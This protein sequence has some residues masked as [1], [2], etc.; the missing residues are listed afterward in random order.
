[1]NLYK[2]MSKEELDLGYDCTKTV[3]D[4]PSVYESCKERSSAIYKQYECRRNIKYANA[5][6]TTFDFFPSQKPNAPTIIFIH[7]GYWQSCQKEDFA[8]AVEGALKKGFQAILVEYTIA[9]EA[10]MTQIMTEMT[11]FLNYLQDNASS[12]N[13]VKGKICLSG[14]SA[15][16]HLTAANKDHPIISHAFPLS[17]LVDLEP[18]SLSFLNDL[19]QLTPEEIEKYSPINHVK[20]GPPMIICVGEAEL[21]ELVRQSKI[22]YEAMKQCQDNIEL[23]LPAGHNHFSLLDELASIDGQITTALIKLI[24]Q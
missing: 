14:H 9:P 16:G 8:Y 10:S 15:G 23:L 5:E 1:M 11:L 3:P 18:I 19:L 2:G 7:G 12:L 13:L 22:Y 6:R 24:E 21:S 20:K 17:P 4:F